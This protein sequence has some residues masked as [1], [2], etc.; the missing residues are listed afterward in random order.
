MKI[1]LDTSVISALFDYR[2]PE[3]QML[4]KEFFNFSELH[5]LFVSDLTILEVEKTPNSE[6]RNQMI[7][8]MKDWEFGI[9]EVDENVHKLAMEYV[10]YEAVP[11]SYMEDAYHIAV[12]TLNS[13]DYLV[14]WNFRHIVRMKTRAVVKMVNSLRDLRY[15]EIISP[16]E[17]L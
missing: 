6:L 5:E 15:V 7:K 13:M 10:K 4:T 14:S 3:R 12:A 11:A 9:L 16:A 2:N 1:Y 17:L 8:F